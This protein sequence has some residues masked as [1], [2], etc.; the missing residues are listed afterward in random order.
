MYPAGNLFIPAPHGRLEAILKEPGGAARGAALVLHPHPLHGGTMHNK[1]V[2][3][4][5]RAMNDA[6]LV[7][8]RVNFRGTGQS[9][10]EHTAAQGG[11]QEDAR[12]ALDYLAEKYPGLPIALAG[13]SFGARVG[14]EVG[15]RDGRVRCLVGIGTPVSI[16][17]R[18]YDFSFLA[19]CRKPLLLVHGE[20]DEFGSVADLRA[21]AARLPSDC[22]ARV[23]I[24]PGA[25]HFFDD[26]LEDL[27]RRIAE[28]AEGQLSAGQ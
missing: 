19:E 9:T 22:P 15:T 20:R 23:E 2:F 27:R 7:A 14:L 26:Q 28:W 8:L 16:P 3:R 24:I 1:V 17:E 13:F 10:G 25:G 21:L 11:E 4:A 18:A 5:A 12:A 6:G